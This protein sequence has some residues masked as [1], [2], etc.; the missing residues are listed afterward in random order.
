[1]HG[2]TSSLGGKL[3]DGRIETKVR[4][5]GLFALAVDSIAPEVKP[6]NFS[7][8]ASVSECKRLKIKIKDC[9]TGINKYDIY[10]NDKWVIGEYDAKNNLLFY[11]I[12]NHFIKGTNNVKVVVSDCVNNKTEKSYKLV[13]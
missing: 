8:N 10:V 6:V 4:N 5:L 3:V 7:N 11:E 9:E 12:D 2:D 13:Y 1:M